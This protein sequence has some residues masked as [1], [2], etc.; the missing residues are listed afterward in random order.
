MTT[1]TSGEF[2][3]QTD[4]G[5]LHYSIFGRG[6]VCISLSGGPGLDARYMGD[7][8]GLSDCVTLV[9][10][11]PRGSGLSQ[12]ADESDWS[13]SAYARDVEILRIA[14]GLQRPLVLGHSHGGF[15][16]LQY[17]IDY[18]DALGGL[19][20]VCTS[21][22]FEGWDPHQTTSR[23]ASEPWYAEASAAMEREAT[24]E[25]EAKAD[26]ATL[27][28][29]YFATPDPYV[30]AVN[31]LLAPYRQNI[32]PTFDFA[33]YD[34]RPSLPSIKAPTLVIAGR[35]DWICTAAMA[36]EMARLI[37]D[38]QLT[39]FEDCG[40]FPW[41]EAQQPFHDAIRDF[42]TKASSQAG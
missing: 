2:D 24:T 3:L 28:P 23:F 8:G 18:P 13:L 35:L 33:T 16:A 36:E 4:D 19:I 31:Q 22:S 10:L 17:A 29:F 37:P 41:L 25:A 15:I 38:A 42:A 11:H 21:A 40:H 6:P 39:V 5:T 7:L 34:L 20:P 32:A 26:L 30:D 27:M 12:H 1:L 14:L 9:Q